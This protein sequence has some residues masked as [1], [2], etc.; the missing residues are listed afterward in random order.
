[1]NNREIEEVEEEAERLARLYLDSQEKP[2]NIISTKLRNNFLYIRVD[3]EDGIRFI[4]TQR[5][6]ETDDEKIV[7]EHLKDCYRQKARKI[8]LSKRKNKKD[9]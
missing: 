8:V 9:S 1:M 2:R 3:G 6:P 7:I 5:D 4:T